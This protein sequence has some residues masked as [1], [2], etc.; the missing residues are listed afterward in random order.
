MG[1]SFLAPVFLAG[2]AAIAIPII[3]HLT[4]RERKEAIAFPSLMF[5]RKIPYRTVRRQKIRH[6]LL[7]LMRSLAV[8]LVVA[9]FARPLLDSSTQ[10]VAAFSTAREL[11]ILL[12]RSHSMAYGDRWSRAVDATR[13]TVNGIGPDDRATLILFAERA[14]AVS[15]P[16]AD[17]AVLQAA[18]DAAEL[19]SGVTRYGPALQL[20]RE[21]V[22]RTDRPR[23]EVV[24]ISD[25][26]KS[27]WDPRQAVRLPEGA[28]FT[29]VNLSDAE[30]AN[31]AVID[32]AV[33]RTRSG[34]R[35]SAIIS[36]R[37][38]NSSGMA[39][40]DVRA[41]LIIDGQAVQE[42]AVNVEA[43]GSASLQ[44]APVVLPGRPVRG[45]VRAGDDALSGDNS[46]HFVIEPE[47]PI[48][49]LIVEPRAAGPDHSLFLRRA[50]SIGSRP[51]FE[52][53][54]R[55]VTRLGPG[56]VDGRSVVILNDA[57]FPDGEA[58]RRLRALVEDGGGLLVALGRRNP[59]GVWPEG[60][61][62]LLPA[63]FGG[64]VERASGGGG[65]L[66]YLDYDHPVF[67][68]FRTPRSGDFSAARFFRYRMMQSGEGSRE[69]AR[70]DDGDAALVEGRLGAGAVLVWA[71]DFENFWNDLAVQPVFLPF[72][73]E[74]VKHLAGYREP[75]S[76][77]AVGQ[78]VDLSLVPELA[79]DEL[80]EDAELLV[81]GPTGGNTVISPAEDSWYVRLD[82]PGFYEVGLAGDGD[83][84]SAVLAA[85]LDP[86]ESD[87]TALDPEEMVGAV[88]AR[89]EAGAAA[90]PIITL[91]A[92]DLER[93]QALWW[94]LL[95]GAA[96]LLLAETLI[97]NRVTRA[98]N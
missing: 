57:P 17:R 27:G 78:V 59:P 53:E 4:H 16:T 82:E 22:E 28:E 43:G 7:F 81:A 83:D 8:I 96:V 26:Q 94:Y 88:V 37:F 87:L 55:R 33:L 14:D 9:A 80:P 73:H 47:Q 89:T 86:V 51:G 77:M 93:R 61:T 62:A 11:V 97:S 25:F 91:S 13:R 75:D 64:P 56:D 72:T 20:A 2:V 54:V 68:L 63:S 67:N 6:W 15:Q 74:I 30:A 23:S 41:S 70:F 50:L 21:I 5:V 36:A 40:E 69:L 52:V 65:T 58:G 19:S 45:V 84:R 48:R 1:F 31:L 38:I 49:V 34:G 35:E 12:D 44:F 60:S 42:Q 90:A 71:S 98:T 24:L 29:I 46:F 32:A 92:E 85:N 79:A 10:A 3:I 18:I 66:S 95:A 76:W 39:F